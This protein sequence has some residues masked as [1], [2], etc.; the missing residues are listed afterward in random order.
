MLLKTC[1]VAPARNGCGDGGGG[2]WVGS[3]GSSG[4]VGAKSCGTGR[5]TERALRALDSSGRPG[6][7]PL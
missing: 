3:S 6:R 7:L 4:G 2:G 5:V 1:M